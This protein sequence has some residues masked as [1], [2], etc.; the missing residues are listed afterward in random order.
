MKE[1]MLPTKGYAVLDSESNL[2]PYTTDNG[3]FPVFEKRKD[4]DRAAKHLGSGWHVV[5]VKVVQN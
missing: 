4:A 1:D 3:Q 2:D 5:R